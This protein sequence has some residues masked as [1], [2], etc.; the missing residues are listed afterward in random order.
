[1]TH[2]C[3]PEKPIGIIDSLE[4][5]NNFFKQLY[6]AMKDDSLPIGSEIEHIAQ[7]LV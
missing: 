4:S 7:L 3:S 5:N 6:T 2:K 1:M